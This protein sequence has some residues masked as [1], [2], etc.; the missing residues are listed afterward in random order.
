M[1][2]ESNT[3]EAAKSNHRAAPSIEV[4]RVFLTPRVVDRGAFDEYASQL[5]DMLAEAAT[6]TDQL[7]ELVA[8]AEET[9]RT[10]AESQARQKAQL[11]LISKLLRALNAKS[12]QVQATLQQIEQ[13]AAS[14]EHFERES[15]RFIDPMPTT[16]CAD[17][18][19]AMI[20]RGQAMRTEIELSIRRLTIVR[21]DARTT[22]RELASTLGAVLKAIEDLGAPPW[23]APVLTPGVAPERSS[24][25]MGQ[26]PV[27]PGAPFS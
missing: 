19:A 15:A 14:T 3:A 16:A 17:G 9:Q 11:E 26:S 7:R 2:R 20:E 18:L 27:P 24:T 21:D 10:A 1:A 12:E 23:G 5:R 25:T 6:R 4:E 8:S 22:A 13:R